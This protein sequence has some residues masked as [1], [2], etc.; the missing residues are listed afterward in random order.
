[1]SLQLQL[2]KN[3]DYIKPVQIEEEKQQSY[4]FL[5]V[6][7]LD[8]DKIIGKED[9]ILSAIN[10]LFEESYPDHH[11]ELEFIYET[12]EGLYSSKKYTTTANNILKYFSDDYIGVI[13]FS[14]PQNF[15]LHKALLIGQALSNVKRWVHHG[16]I[17]ISTHNQNEILKLEFDTERG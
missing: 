10:E 11:V 12:N 14:S 5:V 16:L 8:I 3:S 1:M 4:R 2:Q 13:A 9:D 7:I 6:Y 17:D 15:T